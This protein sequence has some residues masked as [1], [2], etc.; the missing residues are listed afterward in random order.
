MG[1]PS[2]RLAA[3]APVQGQFS[4][5]VALTSSAFTF[6]ACLDWWLGKLRVRFY[7]FIQEPLQLV[8]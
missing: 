8:L 5:K 6:L 4:R 7:E 3:F 2:R 1:T